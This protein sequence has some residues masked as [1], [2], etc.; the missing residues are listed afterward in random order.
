MGAARPQLDIVPTSLIVTCKSWPRWLCCLDWS[1]CIAMESCSEHLIF[2]AEIPHK[3][4]W[5]P[6]ISHSSDFRLNHSTDTKFQFSI[7]SNL[8][9]DVQLSTA[10]VMWSYPRLNI[11]MLWMGTLVESC[12]CSAHLQHILCKRS[13][14]NRPKASVFG[15]ASGPAIHQA[16]KIYKLKKTNIKVGRSLALHR[17][18]KSPF[19]TDV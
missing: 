2:C 1:P 11:W 13:A 16:Y 15:G 14:T 10:C 4:G 5:N 18:Q 3:F 7:N 9:R 12:N 17:V 19:C 8:W 6:Q